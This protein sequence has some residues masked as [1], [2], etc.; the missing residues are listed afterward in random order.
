[1]A[2]VASYQ[3]DIAVKNIVGESCHA[4]YNSVPGCIY[5]EPEISFVGM[6]EEE[7]KKRYDKVKTGVFPFGY[8]GRAQ[9][10][11]ALEGVVK[12]ICEGD[13]EQIVGVQII[14]KNAS[15]IIHEGVMAIKYELSV[16]ELID[17]IHAHPTLSESFKEACEDV[18]GRSVNKG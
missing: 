3:A 9:T 16:H 11:D 5:T 2:H 17:V 13:Y 1:M 12:V 18:L 7:A 4:D 10:M 8:S 15:E 14:G 6:N